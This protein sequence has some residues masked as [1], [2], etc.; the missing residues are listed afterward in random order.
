[1]DVLVYCIILY[2]YKFLTDVNFTNPVFDFHDFIFMNAL[3]QV[4]IFN[5]W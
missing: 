3:S 4:Y 2:T 1:M 5:H